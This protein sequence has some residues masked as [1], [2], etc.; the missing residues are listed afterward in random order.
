MQREKHK[1][2][3]LDVENLEWSRNLFLLRENLRKARDSEKL[4]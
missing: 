2:S 4:I 3:T 1:K